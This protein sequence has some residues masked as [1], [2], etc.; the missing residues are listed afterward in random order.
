M[1]Y[2]GLDPYTL[3][4]VYVPRKYEEKKLQRALLQYYKK[5]NRDLVEKALT[6]AGRRD[7]IGNGAGCLI[8]A[9]P[10]GRKESGNEAKRPE[11]QHGRYQKTTAG[12][13]KKHR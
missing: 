5:E 6:I 3:E 11:K 4:P 13:R 10:G 8:P 9:A 7:L 1:F 12:S 2:T